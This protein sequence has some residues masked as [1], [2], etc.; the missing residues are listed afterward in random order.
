[1]VHYHIQTMDLDSRVFEQWK[2]NPKDY[3]DDY[4]QIQISVKISI[5]K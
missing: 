4:F 1:M 2:N 3:P 5:P